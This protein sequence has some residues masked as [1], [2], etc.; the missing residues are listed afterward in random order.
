MRVL[1]I[2]HFSAQQKKNLFKEIEVFSK[3]PLD[4]V[5]LKTN[6]KVF[7][8]VLNGWVFFEETSK[9]VI[10]AGEPVTK[11]KQNE[12][13]SSFISW[14][15]KRQKSV[16][17]YY[18]SEDF[19][20]EYFDKYELGTSS[21]INLD[22]FT[23]KGYAA[24][25]IRRALNQGEKSNLYFIEGCK[26]SISCDEI[27]SIYSNWRKSRRGP[28]V[29]FLLS[30]PNI[31]ICERVFCVRENEKIAALVSL[32][33]YIKQG[34]K[35]YY[36]DDMIQHPRGHKLAMDF[37]LSSLILKLKRE[38]ALELSLGLNVFDGVG[39]NSRLKLYLTPFC[40]LEWPYRYRGLRKFK[41]KFTKTR[42]KRYL[43]LSKKR[44]FLLQMKAIMQVTYF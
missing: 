37:L 1:E 39:F 14:A 28:R 34:R 6:K 36:L 20:H 25:D 32:F 4:L 35:C 38:G 29:K 40:F 41:S 3:F 8:D 24:R 33:S 10:I 31:E 30:P 23:T 19:T 21:V 27:D 7:E 12:L 9:Q 42:V 16:C 17:G 15:E 43:I 18:V 22:S 2:E 26:K 11:T 44:S 13:M 5:G